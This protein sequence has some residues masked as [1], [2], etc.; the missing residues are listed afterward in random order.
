MVWEVSLAAEGQL[1][2]KLKKR[3]RTM[4]TCRAL[5]MMTAYRRRVAVLTVLTFVAMC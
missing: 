3:K 2:E 1:E 4:Y 5:L